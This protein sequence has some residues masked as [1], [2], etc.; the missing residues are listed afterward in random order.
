MCALI[1]SSTTSYKCSWTP[2]RI[3][4]SNRPSCPSRCVFTTLR[5]HAGDNK[6]VPHRQLLSPPKVAA[7]GAPTEIQIMLGWEMNTRC[8][9]IG[10]PNDKFVAWIGD[11]TDTLTLRRITF[12]DLESLAGRINHTSFVIPL[13]RHFIYRLCRRTSRY[14]H[15]R[16]HGTLS[17]MEIQ[18]LKLWQQFLRVARAG[19][20]MN[21]VVTRQPN[22]MSSSDSCPHRL[23]GFLL[24]S[25]A[26]HLRIPP[27]S[28]LHG[29][30]I[31]NN[32]L[33]FLAMAVSIWLQVLELDAS[34]DCILA[35][36]DSTSAIG[37]LY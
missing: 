24:S 2:P 17:E 25:H 31:M 23:G 30:S 1:A 15:P 8:L 27:T 11:I 36:A 7:E 33:E 12:A 32:V 28:P 16:Q 22:R 5:S 34:E 6:P 18:D 26:W 4:D 19:I 3:A 35:L 13:L 29:D 9:L 21:R 10:L 14:L 37:W 20:S